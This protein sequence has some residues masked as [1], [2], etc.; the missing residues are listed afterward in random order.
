MTH[1][2]L[3]LL[4]S[5]SAGL[6]RYRRCCQVS[7]CFRYHG[8]LGE[9]SLIFLAGQRATAAVRPAAACPA[10]RRGRGH[11]ARPPGTRAGVPGQVSHPHFGGRVPRLCTE[12]GLAASCR[13][14][15]VSL[16]RLRVLGWLQLCGW[17]SQ[18]A[19]SRAHRQRDRVGA[20]CHQ[21]GNVARLS[22]SQ[23][24][25]ILCLRLVA[26]AARATCSAPER[27]Q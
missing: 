4:P 19:I 8:R 10:G 18:V 15:R 12:T 5:N 21:R 16:R 23:S 26:A 25:S 22:D 11:S 17:R 2:L 24:P 27:S 9:C 3:H 6:A 13:M 7:G 20:G 1:C 14:V